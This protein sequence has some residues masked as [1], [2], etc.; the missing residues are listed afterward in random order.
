MDSNNSETA[1]WLRNLPLAELTGSALILVALALL[2]AVIWPVLQGQPLTLSG[3][4]VTQL[5]GGVV[6]LFGLGSGLIL[7]RAAPYW[8]ALIGCALSIFG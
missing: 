2:V 8:I 3:K 5:F 7:Q 6:M 4:Q 1:S